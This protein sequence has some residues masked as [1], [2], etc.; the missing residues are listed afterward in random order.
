MVEFAGL[1]GRA[2]GIGRDEAGGVGVEH[3]GLLHDEDRGDACGTVD[4]SGGAGRGMSLD[5]RKGVDG[6]NRSFGVSVRVS[7]YHN[8][9]TYLTLET[10]N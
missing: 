7:I 3:G 6:K 1:D 9:L 10:N 4:G 8:S 5:V 2:E